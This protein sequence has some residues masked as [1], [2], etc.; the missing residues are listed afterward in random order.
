MNERPVHIIGAGGIGI[1]VGYALFNAGRQ[2][3]LIEKDPEKLCYKC[4][5]EESGKFGTLYVRSEIWD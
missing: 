2:V 5:L 4:R 1:A 3:T